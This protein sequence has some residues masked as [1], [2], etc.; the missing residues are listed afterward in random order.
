MGPNHITSIIAFLLSFPIGYA[1]LRVSRDSSTVVRHLSVSLFCVAAA[2]AWRTFLW[3][4]LP[5]ILSESLWQ[6]MYLRSGGVTINTGFNVIFAYGC[7]RG[8]QAMHLMVPVEERRRWPW[9]R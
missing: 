9:W 5:W 3:D 2:F 7:Y 1:Y 4:I 8:M 6:A